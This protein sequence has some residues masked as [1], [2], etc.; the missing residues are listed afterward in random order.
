MKKA[1][2][3]FFLFLY[4]FS[5]TELKQLVKLPLLFQHYKEHQALD[6]G[7]SFLQFLRIHYHD[8]TVIDD[9]YDKDMQLPFKNHDL[10][11]SNTINAITTSFFP[12]FV[13]KPVLT[14]V[15]KHIIC[16]DDFINAV[17]LSSVWQ[18]PR[19]AVV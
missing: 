2:A 7:I 3:V 12:A 11:H 17:Y 5:S 14:S 16:N 18:P 15:Q 10:C 4:L 9:D 6:G 19:M 13:E 8:A 1:A